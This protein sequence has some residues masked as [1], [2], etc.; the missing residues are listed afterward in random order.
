[1]LSNLK[2]GMYV[3]Q[4][5]VTD[6]SNQSA[7]DKVSVLVLTPEQSEGEYWIVAM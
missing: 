5:K 3:F 2:P 6:S 7:M 1:M 4:L